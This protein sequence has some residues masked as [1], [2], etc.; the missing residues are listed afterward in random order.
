MGPLRSSSPLALVAL[1]LHAGVLHAGVGADLARQIR[2]DLDPQECYRVRDLTLV[3]EDLRLYLTDGVLLFGKHSGDDP[4]SALFVAGLQGGDGEILALPPDRGERQSLATFTRSPNLDEHFRVAAMLFTDR[5]YRDL[6]AQIGENPANRKSPEMGLTLAPEWSATVRNLAASFES[7][8]ALDLLSGPREPR[9]FFFAAIGGKLL[10][11]FDAVYD[12]R[13]A[14]QITIGQMAYRNDRSY[15]DVWTSFEPRSLRNG[16]RPAPKPEFELDDF[17]ID[18]VLLPPD[19]R[20]EAVARVKV[21]VNGGGRVLPFDLSRRMRL[22]AV[23]IDGRPAEVFEPESLRS[24]LIHDRGN[25]LRLVI[26]AQPLAAG[27]QYEVEFHYSGAVV[28]DAGNRV[29]SIAARASWYPNRGMQFAKFD[30]TFRYPANLDLVASGARVSDSLEGETRVTRFRGGAPIRLAGFNLGVYDREKIARGGR[31]VEVCANRNLE[32]A[33]EPKPGA[34][35]DPVPPEPLFPGW[36]TRGRAQPNAHVPPDAAAP[37]TGAPASPSAGRLRELASDVA[38]ALDFM[39][40]R[41]G[42]PPLS[43]LTVSPAPGT[44]GQGFPGLIYLSTLSYLG[45]ANRTL[46]GISESEQFFFSE[47]L[48]A[49]ETAHQWWGNAVAPAHYR[50]DWLLES[51]ANY[52]ALLYLTKH[53]GPR[54]AE[55]LLNRYRENLLARTEGGKTVESAGPISLG[56]RLQSSLSPT[57][58]RTIVYEKG[59]WILHMLRK[60]MGDER[61]DAFLGELRRR[62]EFKALDTESFRLL[63]A[64]FLP[65]QSADPKLDAFF[66]Q[67]VYSTGIPS[68]K[69]TYSLAGRAPARKLTVT[70]EQ[71]GV[72]ENF[73]VA[74]PVEI[75]FRGAKTITRLVRTSSEPA[76][77]AIPVP[78]PPSKVLLDPGNTILAA[79]K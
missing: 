67:W 2:A 27:R 42:P 37:L 45:P 79:K 11:N 17:R 78:L 44:Y 38:A 47:M 5:T 54:A 75:Q 22:S 13:A 18:S 29:Y 30:L 46:A 39:S 74:V 9:A 62:F 68:L 4:V 71:T 77:I 70:V 76:E 26:P 59:T 7:R 55:T 40:A 57:A 33:L 61:F 41:F 14:G 65:P 32:R 64:S 23:S 63:A 49:H 56:L 34:P 24:N 73:S 58:W 69:M 19:L 72:D 28:T 48:Y 1:F 52:S 31:T 36:R 21:K 3:K 8:L 15:F 20:M 66:D 53:K 60:R 50:D 25:G 51:L 16:T 10:G 43:T 6:M 35:A 12:A